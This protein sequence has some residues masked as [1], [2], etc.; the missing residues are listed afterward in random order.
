MVEEERPLELER[1][2]RCRRG[3]AHRR[4]CAPRG[5]AAP[6]RRTIGLAA[7]AALSCLA[8]AA[9]VT[10]DD[11]VRLA[12]DRAPAVHS[13]TADVDAALAKVRGARAAYWPRASGVAQYGHSEGYDTAITNGGVTQLGVTVEAPIL[14][15]G[16]RALDAI[17]D[18]PPDLA[19][20]A[21]GHAASLVLA[22][23]ALP[24][25]FRAALQPVALPAQSA[26]ARSRARD[27]P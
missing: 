13:A 21:A 3:R 25:V 14:D 27:L 5:E 4:Q 1:V 17:H 16:L 6:V 10:V 19:T 11:C 15:G 20:L 26:T 12:L 9:P 24:R 23:P 2:T 18:G 22:L 8:A 7:F